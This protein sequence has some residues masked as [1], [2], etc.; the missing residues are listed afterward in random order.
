MIDIN[1]INVDKRGR[2]IMEV[3]IDDNL[4]KFQRLTKKIIGE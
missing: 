1:N 3:K 2:A 4:V